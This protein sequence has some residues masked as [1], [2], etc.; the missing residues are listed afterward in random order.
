MPT[1]VFETTVRAPLERVWALHDDVAAALPALSP[2]A[3]RVKIEAADLPVRVGS[4]IVITARGPLGVR[5]RWVAK[6]VEHAPPGGAGRAAARFVDEQE[7]GP[8][9]S[10]RHE[11][12][13]AVVN[14]T[15]TRLTDV[16]TYV[17]RFGALGRIADRLFVRR[18]V[19]AMFRHRHEVLPRLLASGPGAAVESSA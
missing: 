16:V 10:W 15:N 13:F 18:Q 3:A 9:E 1:L 5:L 17:V 19:R 11:H 8:F 7:S 14:D 6:I 4:R 12:T 2:P